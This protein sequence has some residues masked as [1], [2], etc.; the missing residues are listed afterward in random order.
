M[1]RKLALIS[2]DGNGVYNLKHMPF[3][4]ELIEGG[5]ASASWTP[6]SRR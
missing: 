1:R 6:S 5:E 4:S 2:L 3:L